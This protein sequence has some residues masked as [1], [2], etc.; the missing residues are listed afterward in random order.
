[1]SNDFH[2]F[3]LCLSVMRSVLAMHGLGYFNNNLSLK[4][5]LIKTIPGLGPSFETKIVDWMQG[6]KKGD[7]LFCMGIHDKN[8]LLYHFNRSTEGIHT[9]DHPVPGLPFINVRKR[10]I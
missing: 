3:E 7:E 4:N 8:Q 9:K 2:R 1:M 5:I 10:L 6:T